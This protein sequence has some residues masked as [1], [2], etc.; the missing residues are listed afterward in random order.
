MDAFHR[1]AFFTT[2]R[3][4]SFVALA[5][6]TL[7]LVFSLEPALA[8]FVG[9][10][11]ALVF[12]LGLVLRVAGL[13][14][15]RIVHTEAWRVLT[16]HQRP[17]GEAARHQARDDLQELLL[18]FAKAAA[19]VA[20]VLHG[21]ALTFSLGKELYSLRAVAEPGDWMDRLAMVW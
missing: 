17:T 10:N 21:S 2:S 19:G 12:S 13:T 4:A 20:A 3:D 7:M 16:P 5:A 15:E 9:G 11:V 6:A 14:D 1:T 18:R 8:C